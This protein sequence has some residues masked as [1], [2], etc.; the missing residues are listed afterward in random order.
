[1]DRRKFLR[2]A[3][4]SLAIPGLMSSFGFSM[5]GRKSLENFLRLASDSNRVLILIYLQGGNDGL[6]TVIPMDQVSV[7]NKVRPH[8][9]LPD[10]KILGLDD[11]QVGLHP[12]LPGFKSLYEEGRLGIVQNVGYPEQNYSHFRST[13]I[14]MSG[15]DSNQLVNSGWPG[16]LLSQEYPQYPDEYP[17]TEMPDPLAIEIGY[18]SSLLFQGPT[19][20]MSMVLNNADSFYNLVDNV[21]EEAPDTVAGDKLKFVRL[22][23]RQSQLYGEVV[24]A[25]AKKV[26]THASYPENNVLGAQ[27][28][29]VSKLIAGGLKTPVYMVRIGGF[30]TH[31]AQVVAGDHTKGE[32]AELLKKVNDAVMA[33]MQDAELQGIDDRVIGMTFSEFGRR[34][35]SNASLGTDHGSA[36][37]LFV[38]G[39]EVTG[40][41]LGNNPTIDSNSTFEHNLEM[42]YDFRQVN[43]SIIEQWFGVSTADTTNVMLN[44]FETLPIIGKP[45]VISGLNPLKTETEAN[46]YPNPLVG[47]TSI[48]FYSNGEPLEVSLMDLQGK[49]V[50][51]IYSGQ[52]KHGK[53]QIIWDASHLIA[54]RY[55]IVFRNQKSHYSKLVVKY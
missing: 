14:W 23:A 47:I 17:N 38:F 34:I 55:L 45:E 2:H 30:D 43:A 15:S 8:V 31:D 4:H 28:K 10:D 22:V 36:A 19:A 44:E 12:S 25:A 53:Q 48:D 21:E 42:Q 18:G 6:N 51:Q 33:F 11:A 27:L 32:H 1:M 41:V 40:G 39:N 9:V 52:T 35:V 49:K 37:P 7:L 26:N 13:D 16:R 5:Q 46:I 50:A 29:I 3:G 54:G 24:T 20:S